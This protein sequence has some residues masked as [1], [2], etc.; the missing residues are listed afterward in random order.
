MAS[1]YLQHIVSTSFLKSYKQN[2]AFVFFTIQ[3]AVLLLSFNVKIVAQPAS[4]SP[5]SIEDTFAMSID[6]ADVVVTAQYA[7]TDSK[8]AVQHIRTINRG[9]IEQQG[10]TNLEQLLQQDLNVRIGQDLLLGSN[11]SLLGVGGEN[12][13]IMID[14]VPIVGRLDGNIDLSQIN[15]NNIERIEIVEGPMSVA[16]GT[17]ALGGVINLITKKSQL[18]SHELTLN[19]QLETRAE[20]SSSIDGGVRFGDDWLLRVN[21]GRDWFDGFSEDTTRSVLWNPKEQWYADASLRYNLE[22]DH[23]LIYR[24]SFFDEEV[25]NLGNIRRPQFKPYAFDDYFLTQ[26]WSHSLLHEGSV[27][28]DYYWQNTLAFNIFNREVN[29]YRHDFDPELLSLTGGDTTTFH[30]YMLR[31]TF[32]SRYRSDWNF[33]VGIDANY[34]IGTGARILDEASDTRGESSI[35]DYAVFGSLRYQPNQK[36][37]LETGLRYAENSKYDA[38]LIP[39]FHA[40]YQLNDNIL[41]RASYGKGFR[42]PS[43]KE[44]YLSFIDIN[45]F[46]IGNPDLRAE[47]SN[48]FQTNL[49]YDKSVGQHRIFANV[50]LFYNQIKDQIQLFP[51]LDQSGEITPTSD[52]QSNRFAYFNLEEAKTQGI[53]FN[54]G[55]HWKNLSL[56]GGYSRIGFFNPLSE[57]VAT[58]DAFTYSNEINGKLGYELPFSGTQLNVFVRRNDQF[59]NFFPTQENG[60]PIA[61]QRTQDGFT[62]MD[63]TASQTLLNNRLN[64]SLGVRNLLNVTQVN[65]QGGSAGMHSSGNTLPV[66]A[67]RS[68][69]VRASIRLFN[70]KAAKFKNR[71]FEQQRKEALRL[72]EVQDELYAS[73]IEDQNEGERVFQFSKWKNEKWSNPKTIAIGDEK[74]FVNNVDAPQL[75]SFKNDEKALSA[76]WLR[77]SNPRNVYDHHIWLSQSKNGGRNWQLPFIPYDSEVPAFYG[78]AKMIPL[79]N[80]RILLTWMDGRDTKELYKDTGRYFPKRDGKLHIRSLELDKKGKVYNEQITATDISPL[81]PFDALE[82]EN[83]G[84]V[85]YRNSDNNIVIATYS[86]GNWTTSNTIS[87]DNWKGNTIAAPI[88]ANH[89]SKLAVAW[90]TEVAKVPQLKVAFSD[91]G[92]TFNTPILVQAENLN[93][94]LDLIWLSEDRLA[95]TWQSS[96]AV[97]LL[98]INQSGEVLKEKTIPVRFLAQPKLTSIEGGVY[99]V[100]QK[101]ETF[102]VQEI[103]N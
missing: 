46:I 47:T 22:N 10:A 51:F 71:P 59:I 25:Q 63:M 34:E 72:H 6:L 26:R 89:Q 99:L 18:F 11:M 35:Y 27:K 74:W 17:D 102:V 8:N 97:H 4:S 58:I 77:K 66:G 41:W 101:G 2:Y 82:V 31:S 42:S 36:W 69:F 91:D 92:A 33:Q 44:L 80:D 98:Q 96:D 45:H 73:W 81:C 39:S 53:N 62:M 83:K 84:I 60:E 88:L 75:M 67:G 5:L 64:V 20:S 40:K 19:Q 95:L 7:P 15:L 38:P 54:V 55:Y 93:E 32:A 50:K 87:E 12:V 85:A 13:K 68:F 28:N 23:R 14:G 79:N 86:D 103:N 78:L 29:S 57:S 37:I 43:L 94:Q 16:Y 65:V 1:S 100:Y 49:S 61:Q 48:N 3:L 21:A 52:N 24:L 76:L 30:T 70:N 9:T 56:E 90:Y